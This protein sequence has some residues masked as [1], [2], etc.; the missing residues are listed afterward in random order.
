MD[1]KEKITEQPSHFDHLEQMSVG[2]LLQHINE[3]DRQVAESVSRAIPQIESL[4][5][6]IEP[7]MERGGR[8]FYIG[9]GT[10]GRMG[11]LDASELPPT[12]GIPDNWV[13]A[14]IAGGDK[15][16]RHAVERAEDITEQ[17]WRDL[18]EYGPTPDDTVIGIAASGT[19]PYVVGA[20]R[21]ARQGGLLTGCIT[22]NPNTP[23]AQT[24]EFP[25]E[26]IVGPEFVTGSSR[27]K[28]GTAQKMVLNM[29]STTLMIRMGRVLGNRM[30]N[31]QLTNNKLID[32]GTRMLQESLGISYDEAR[33]RLLETGTVSD[34]L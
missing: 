8:L 21:Q 18:K 22:S 14:I 13:M 28:S 24:A 26:T 20:I 12:F 4:V 7:R 3:E 33:R 30:I 1:L 9:A 27:M 31:M 6:A 5:E 23:L 19:T 34:C 16:L 17:G 2:E 11:V 10:S 32:R 25:V 29:I 15:A